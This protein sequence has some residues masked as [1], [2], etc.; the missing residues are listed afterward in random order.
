ML[1]CKTINSCVDQAHLYG[2]FLRC[3]LWKDSLWILF[4]SVTYIYLALQYVLSANYTIYVNKNWTDFTKSIKL[5][6]AKTFWIVFLFYSVHRVPFYMVGYV[7][8]IIQ[9]LVNAN[10]K[11]KL[12]IW[13]SRY[14][15]SNIVRRNKTSL[16]TINWYPYWVKDD[17]ITKKL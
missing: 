2:D 16:S 9:C 17:A 1:F 15:C 13:I 10:I 8:E 12:Q 14:P 5:Y 11:L 4:S 3:N 7:H 6:G